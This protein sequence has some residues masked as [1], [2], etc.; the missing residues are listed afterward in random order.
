[1]YTSIR[2]C[3]KTETFSSDSVW[4][5]SH[6]YAV[7]TVTEN[8]SFQ[9][10]CSEWRRFSSTCGVMKT[11]VFEYDDVINYILL[12]LHLLCEGGYRFYII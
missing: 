6:T 5:T 4:P 9:K 11:E 7:K 12:T 10:R 3:L 2:F 1:M 8:A